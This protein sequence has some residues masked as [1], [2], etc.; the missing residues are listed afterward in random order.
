MFDLTGRTALVT[1]AT[2]GIGHHLAAVA[3]HEVAGVRDVPDDGGVQL[4]PGADLAHALL[5][6]EPGAAGAH[7]AGTWPGVD[8]ALPA[9]L[10]LEVLDR[11]RDIDEVAIDARVFEAAVEEVAGGADERVAKAVLG[12]AGLFADKDEA[13]T[14][15][16]FA[17]DGLGGVRPEGAAFAGA[18]RFA[19]GGE[20]AAGGQERGGRKFE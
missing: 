18:A 6:I 9:R 10:P 7:F 4:P 15:I 13:G 16:P 11:V 17:E 20:V 2:G 3:R 1:G 5:G 12:V 19:Q 14:G 8:A